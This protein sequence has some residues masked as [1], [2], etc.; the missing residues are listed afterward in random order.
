[1]AQSA[2]HL[3]LQARVQSPEATENLDTASLHIYNP[4]TSE[5]RA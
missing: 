1:M 2:K 3:L 5:V 4:N